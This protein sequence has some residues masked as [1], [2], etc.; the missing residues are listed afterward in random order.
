MRGEIDG[1][2]AAGAELVVVGSGRPWHAKA[3]R[4]EHGLDFPLRVDPELAAYRAAGLR[5]GAWRTLGPRVLAHAARAFG[6][7]FRQG[8][9]QGD[10]W[11]QGGVFLVKPA[12]RRAPASRAVRPWTR[13][14]MRVRP[15]GPCQTA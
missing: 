12:A 8:A 15:S 10:P 4:D 13:R 14:A 2:R 3:F 5:R 9:V 11:Q 7:G 6:R 1:I